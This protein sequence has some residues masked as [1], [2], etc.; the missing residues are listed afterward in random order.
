MNK[1]YTFLIFFIIFINVFFG[2]EG[3]VEGGDS[4]L[5]NVGVDSDTGGPKYRSYD[6]Y[7][8]P[9][10]YFGVGMLSFFGDIKSK[11]SRIGPMGNFNAGV[12]CGIE[13]RWGDWF[14]GSLNIIYGRLSENGIKGNQHFNFMTDI[15]GL[16]V[17]CFYH[18]DNDFVFNKKSLFSPYI[19]LG[20]GAVYFD[21]KGDLLYRDGSRY[22]YWGD[23]TIRDKEEGV[24]Y[25]IGVRVLNRDNVYETKYDK[26]KSYSH[27]ALTIPFTFGV[28]FKLSDRFEAFLSTTY[29]STTSDKIDNYGSNKVSLFGG[30]DGYLYSAASLKYNIG[31]KK[32]PRIVEIKDS[33]LPLNPVLTDTL[34]AEDTIKKLIEDSVLTILISDTIK[35]PIVIVKDTLSKYG[36][37]EP[38]SKERVYRIQVAA[39][40]DP[41]RVEYYK[42]TFNIKDEDVYLYLEKGLYKFSI[43]EYKDLNKAVSENQ[44]FR[45]TYGIRSFVVSF[46][47]G[48]RIIPPQ[49]YEESNADLSEEGQ[50]GDVEIIYRIQLGSSSNKYAKDYYKKRYNTDE[51]IFIERYQG[52]YKY[53]IGNY[54]TYKMAKQVNDEYRKRGLDS[55]I[56]AFK[57]GKRCSV[58]YAKKLTNQ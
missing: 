10:V 51:Q 24:N 11:S 42:K 2:Q 25:P 5:S 30:N 38:V 28:K 21:P 55:F 13:K 40:K 6:K 18:F 4:L 49:K 43:N 1:I 50:I 53:Y 47:D 36:K 9:T 26:D 37:V 44:K 33:I 46:K 35:T 31:G 19:G 7:R 20:L 32:A 22:Y 8:L 23:G 57:N 12:N 56:I 16:D 45:K 3:V 27:I 39:L 58:R 48:K 34:L 14:G 54:A 29:Y 15:L 52:A 17:N 41:N